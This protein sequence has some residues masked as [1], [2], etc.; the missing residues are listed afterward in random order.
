MD[1]TFGHYQYSV[2]L[3]LRNKPSLTTTHL[4][5][6]K[7]DLGAGLGL[8]KVGQLQVSVP[9]NAHAGQAMIFLFDTGRESFVNPQSVQITVT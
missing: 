4:I 1:I 5:T 7:W 6:M 8:V 3:L 9:A 2:K